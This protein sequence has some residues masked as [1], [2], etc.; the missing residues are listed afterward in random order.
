MANGALTTP[1]MVMES[2]TVT[3]EKPKESCE[4]SGMKA[5]LGNIGIVLGLAILL[6]VC[7][8]FLKRWY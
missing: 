5:S 3:A 4:A 2:I 8:K 6:I 7:Y 1:S